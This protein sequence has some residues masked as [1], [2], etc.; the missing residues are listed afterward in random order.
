[1]TSAPAMQEL[2]AKVPV[3]RAALPDGSGERLHR[4]GI[5][6]LRAL[7]GLAAR[8]PAPALRR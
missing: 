1:M 6:D 8:Q 2:L 5:R 7:R 4:M 3:R